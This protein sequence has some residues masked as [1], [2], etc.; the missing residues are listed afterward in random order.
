MRSPN[1]SNTASNLSGFAS[2]RETSAIQFFTLRRE[3]AKKVFQSKSTIPSLDLSGSASLRELS[4]IQGRQEFFTLRRQA[5]KKAFQSKSTIPSL[6]LSVSVPLRETSAIQFFTLRRQDAKKAY[7][8]KSS[9]PS[10]NLSDLASL[11]EPSPTQVREEF[12]TLRRQGAKE[13]F[14]SNHRISFRNLS[15]FASLREPST[16]Q[17]RQEFFTLRRKDAKR[18]NQSKHQRF[19]GHSIGDALNAVLDHVLAEIDEEAKSFIHQ[20]QIGQDLFAVDRIQR[21]DRFQLHD[22]EIIDDQIGAETFVEPDPIPRDRNSYLSFHGVAVLAQFM[23]KQDFVYDFEDAWPEPSVQAVGSVNDHSRDFILFHRAKLVLL[24]PACEAKNLSAVASLRG[25]SS[26][27]SQEESFT[28]KG[29]CTKKTFESKTPISSQDLSGLA[30]LREISARQAREEFF[31]LRR[32]G[33][34]KAY[35]SKSPVSS[36]DLSGL[37]SLREIAATHSQQKSFTLRR[38]DVKRSTSNDRISVP[39]LSGFA[40]LRETSPIPWQR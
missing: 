20:P 22:H 17:G 2:L 3:G 26:M 4:A 33:A 11:R 15:G 19:F 18:R 9:V 36:L 30:S 32:Q 24:L 40:P 21:S 7:Q 37:A 6:D 31:T 13:A 16:I 12:F 14:E 39:N 34:T 27:Q 28:L 1:L 29:E 35:E 8:S 5:A 23:R 38:K 25:I 10:L